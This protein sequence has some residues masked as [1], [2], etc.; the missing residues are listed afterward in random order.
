[1]TPSCLSP[2]VTSSTDAAREQRMSAQPDA[3][4]INDHQGED[5]LALTRRGLMERLTDPYLTD[6]DRWVLQQFACFFSGATPEP[7]PR[8]A[9]IRPERPLRPPL[10]RARV[11]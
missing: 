11:A 6:H 10:V 7:D 3:L 4:R 5:L 1:M 8:V 9:R 2:N